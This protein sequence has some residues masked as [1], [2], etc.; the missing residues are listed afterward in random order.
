MRPHVSSSRLLLVALLFS[1]ADVPANEGDPD[2][3]FA[4]SGSTAVVITSNTSASGSAQSVAASDN[5]TIVLAGSGSTPGASQTLAIARLLSDGTPDPAFGNLVGQPGRSAFDL[6]SAGLTFFYTAGFAATRVGSAPAYYLGGTSYINPNYVGAVLRVNNAGQLD[7]AFGGGNGYALVNVAGGATA[8]NVFARAVAALPDGSVIVGGEDYDVA[9][10][11]S[12]VVHFLAD[13]TRDASFG[14]GGALYFSGPAG[15][16]H[17]LIVD[18]KSDAQGNVLVLFRQTTASGGTR[19]ALARASTGGT[20]DTAFSGG[21]TYAVVDF[22]LGGNNDVPGHV[23]VQD[24]G[25]YVLAG[26]ATSATPPYARCGIARLAHDGTPDATFAVSGAAAYGSS[27]C[28]DVVMQ[29]AHR[30]IALGN[31]GSTAFALRVLPDGSLDASFGTAGTAL[32][33][34]FSALGT[35]VAVDH[36]QRPLIAGS[37]S[38]SPGLYGARLMSDGIFAAGFELP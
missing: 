19:M 4:G 38:G 12:Y 36:A 17:V 14:S 29:D 34:T 25:K 10:N 27:A 18:M 13:G 31:D 1:A 9:G 22:Q 2:L 32:L 33:S 30:L 20:L 23:A 24:D 16:Q 6:S 3:S 8:H 21:A 35:A 28:V 11:P 15:S 37:K 7:A 5:G 26:T